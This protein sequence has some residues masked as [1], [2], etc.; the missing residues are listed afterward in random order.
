MKNAAMAVAAS[1]VVLRLPSWWSKSIPSSSSRSTGRGLTHEQLH[2]GAIAEIG[3]SLEGV[4]QMALETVFWSGHRR[5]AAL[6]QRLAERGARSLLSKRTLRLAGSSRA[7]KP[8]A[9]R[10]PR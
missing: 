9:P 5:D 2:R 1:R 10:P 8:A 6:A 3:A 7:I 4:L